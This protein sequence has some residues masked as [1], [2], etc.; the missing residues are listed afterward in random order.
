MFLGCI[1][2]W[3]EKFFKRKDNIC[4]LDTTDDSLNIQR[5]TSFNELLEKST[6]KV[7]NDILQLQRAFE[8]NIIKEEQINDEDKEKLRVLYKEQ[9]AALK[10][11]I[12]DYKNKIN[13]IE[14]R[15]SN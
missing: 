9:I 4:L 6:N 7:N 5:E 14:S 15:V 1:K 13:K 11:S 12:N 8:K 2:R 10:R 3:L